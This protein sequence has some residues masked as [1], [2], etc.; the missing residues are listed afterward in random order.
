MKNIKYIVSGIFLL[1]FFVGCTATTSN[2]M[3]GE[4][5]PKAYKNHAKSILVLPAK[6]TTTSVDATEHFRYTITQALSERRYYVFPVHL[7]DSFFKSE[8]ITEAEMIR[9]IPIEKLKEITRCH[10]C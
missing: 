3:L 10:F 2:V 6:N 8:N 5:Y 9:Q 7:V 4:L 1:V